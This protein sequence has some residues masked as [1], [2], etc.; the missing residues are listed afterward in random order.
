MADS[1]GLPSA[2]EQ[3]DTFCRALFLKNDPEVDDFLQRYADSCIADAWGYAPAEH[4]RGAAAAAK[5]EDPDAS[6]APEVDLWEMR[7]ASLR[8]LFPARAPQRARVR[9]PVHTWP[10][11]AL[12]PSVL[13]QA[14]AED[15]PLAPFTY[16]AYHLFCAWEVRTARGAARAAA[17]AP[18]AST[19][20]AS[21][22][23]ALWA[24]FYVTGQAENLA[25]IAH[26]AAQGISHAKERMGKRMQPAAVY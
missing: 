20:S 26:V 13:E 21:V 22:L 4:T 23:D 3:C 6:I 12:D 9:S 2:E 1:K 10:V 7:L 24:E 17:L 15:P 19:L 8:T 5:E 18:A 11:P 16:T 25:R 14:L